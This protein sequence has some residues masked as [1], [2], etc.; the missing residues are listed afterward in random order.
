MVDGVATWDEFS[1]NNG[2][3]DNRISCEW[4]NTKE[5]AEFLSITPNALRI[6]VCRGKIKASRLGKRLRFKLSDLRGLL[7]SERRRSV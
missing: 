6:W 5:A 3:F 7:L 2:L 1:R 4:L